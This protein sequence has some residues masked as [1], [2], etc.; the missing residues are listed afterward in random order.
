MT[1]MAFAMGPAYH[2]V[3]EVESTTSSQTRFT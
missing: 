2:V 3:Y 1:D